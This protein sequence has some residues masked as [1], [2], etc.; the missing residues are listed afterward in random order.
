MAVTSYFPGKVIESSNFLLVTQSNATMGNFDFAAI[1]S[2]DGGITWQF[3]KS[4][5]ENIYTFDGCALLGQAF[6]VGQEDLASEMRLLK[7]TGVAPLTFEVVGFAEFDPE[8]YPLSIAAHSSTKTIAL[9]SY[10]AASDDM[11]VSF[12]YDMCRNWDTIQFTPPDVRGPDSNR[13]W[14]VQ[15]DLNGKFVVTG[16]SGW[17]AVLDSRGRR[18]V[19]LSSLEDQPYDFAQSAL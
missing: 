10:S 1:T 4:V 13:I 7:V 6:L 18:L 12:S 11:F 15:D 8:N 5:G 16:G 14:A 17:V 9:L 3:E 2:G 19:S